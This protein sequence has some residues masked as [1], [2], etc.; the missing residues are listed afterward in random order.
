MWYKTCI[1]T[2]SFAVSQSKRILS[3][4]G[5]KLMPSN[6]MPSVTTKDSKHFMYWFCIIWVNTDWLH[7]ANITC[8]IKNKF[9]QLTSSTPP[10]SV[11]LFLALY[12][13]NF[14]DHFVVRFIFFGHSVSPGFEPSR[15]GSHRE[16]Y[17]EVA[18]LAIC[19]LFSV[20]SDS[21]LV[22]LITEHNEGFVW[23]EL[24]QNVPQGFLPPLF[25]PV[26]YALR[27]VF[28]YRVKTVQH[29]VD[30]R[31]KTTKKC[32][33]DKISTKRV[34]WLV[35]IWITHGNNPWQQGLYEWRHALISGVWRKEI[36]GIWRRDISGSVFDFPK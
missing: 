19:H 7:K 34:C 9:T 20:L 23:T 32:D 8:Q 14:S 11:L 29:R 16:L 25:S 2:N 27:W 36:S 3:G 12:P 17:N 10:P 30:F 35:A 6:A 4:R 13:T 1:C 33:F 22:Q 5:L 28:S 18:P 26:F 31:L 21:C 24:I 15:I